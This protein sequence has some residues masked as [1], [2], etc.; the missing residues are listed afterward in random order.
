MRHAV[1]V[2]RYFHVVL[3]LFFIITIILGLWSS[4]IRWIIFGFSPFL[5]GLT[6]F[7]IPPTKNYI[8]EIKSNRRISNK[9]YLTD[10]QIFSRRKK[11]GIVM[12]FI[13]II[14]IGGNLFLFFT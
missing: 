6:L 9:S 8:D 4:E 2:L 3:G 7:F 11:L 5:M 13:G 12:I 1:K 14:A 10:T